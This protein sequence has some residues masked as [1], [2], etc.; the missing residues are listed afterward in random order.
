MCED[1]LYLA[2][3]A[4]RWLDDANFAKGPAQF[5]KSL[6]MPFRLIVPGLVR[7]KVE[8]TLK[9][10]GF[11]RHTPAEQDELA[12]RDVDALAATIREE[13]FLM[14][15]RPCGA[16]ATVFSFVAQLLTPVF[17]TPTRTAAEK[18]QNLVSC[19]DRIQ[20]QYFSQ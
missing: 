5:F 4:T 10:Q 20:R 11:G 2:L 6:P 13:A 1:H 8:K 7:R 18:H 9:L 15:D 19:R 14:G 12:I 3:M 17:V 16:D